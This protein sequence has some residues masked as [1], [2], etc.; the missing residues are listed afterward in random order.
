[1]D[2]KIL[3]QVEKIIGDASIASIRSWLKGKGKKSS[4]GTRERMMARVAG[5][6]DKGEITFAELEDALVGIEEA[7]DKYILL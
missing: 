1:M 4:A 3:D 7:G 2:K 6:I 5:L